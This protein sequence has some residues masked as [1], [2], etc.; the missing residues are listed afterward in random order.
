MAAGLWQCMVPAPM[1]G[2][3]S[4]RDT[5]SGMQWNGGCDLIGFKH[6]PSSA[7]LPTRFYPTYQRNSLYM[8]PASAPVSPAVL[9]R[10][11]NGLTG[12]PRT[13]GTCILDPVQYFLGVSAEIGIWGNLL[14]LNGTG[15]SLLF[16]LVVS[17]IS[18]SKAKTTS[19]IIITIVV[20]MKTSTAVRLSALFIYVFNSKFIHLYPQEAD[21]PYQRH[22]SNMN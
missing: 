2:I 11:E 5:L 16:F 6:V 3:H 20:K 18:F 7:K 22:S 19:D 17:S 21:E 4:Q 10:G 1:L 14:S 8:Y 15:H 12:R 13:A 9:R